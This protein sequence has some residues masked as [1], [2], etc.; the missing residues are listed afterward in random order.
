MK[1]YMENINHE[2]IKLLIPKQVYIEITPCLEIEC[3]Q[4]LAACLSSPN[5][6]QGEALFRLT[7]QWTCLA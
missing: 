5:S 3:W 4:A 7:K 6:L 1:Q 2:H